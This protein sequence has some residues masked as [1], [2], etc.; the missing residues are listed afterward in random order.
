MRV[1][2][3]T[4][5]EQLIGQLGRQSYRQS[6]LQ[7]QAAT[8]QRLT[9]PED[10]PTATR[11]VIDLQAEA[12]ALGHY[13]NNAARLKE[14]A[15]A[16]Y[17]AIKALKTISDRANE[18]AVLGDSL[19]SPE[20]MSI[21]ATE[22]EQLLQQALQVANTRYGGDFLF[23]GTRS[24]RAPFAPVTGPGG[25]VAAV[26]YQGNI[27]ATAAEI[28]QGVT[29]SV[30][31][32]GAN[33]TGAGP[34]GLVADA[35]TGADFFAHLISLRDHLRAGEAAPVTGADAPALRKDEEN[36]ILQMA[37]NGALQSRLDSATA[38]GS[39]RAQSIDKLISNEADADL[40][41]TLVRLTE[42]QN[43]YQA[44][45][46]SGGTILNQSLLDYLR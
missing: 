18:I 20:Q 10:D 16:E 4:F 28:A 7:N 44:A 11:R 17:N 46:Q 5:P 31:V 13:R 8:G 27:G 6:R 32:P 42:T 36:F 21:Y 15:G 19:K 40:A 1:T 38:I 14:Q 30:Q 35:R 43:A 3:N 25:Q 41:Q 37:D 34:R 26:A 29:L 9:L 22:V 33:A 45:L 23:A 2:T 24:D 39:L 12:Q